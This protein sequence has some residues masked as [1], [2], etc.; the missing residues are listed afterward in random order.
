MN[1]SQISVVNVLVI[2]DIQHDDLRDI[3]EIFE[4]F[5]ISNQMFSTKVCT[6]H[7]A[8]ILVSKFSN[9]KRSSEMHTNVPKNISNRFFLLL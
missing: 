9:S 3:Y 7:V 6:N 1:T 2:Q 4:F 5:Y 8:N